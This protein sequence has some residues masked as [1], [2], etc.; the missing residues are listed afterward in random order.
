MISGQRKQRTCSAQMFPRPRLSVMH[1][2]AFSHAYGHV[3]GYNLVTNLRGRGQGR[4]RG[5]SKGTTVQFRALGRLSQELYR[6][7][8]QRT[9]QLRPCNRWALQLW[10]EANWASKAE[11]SAKLLCVQVK[12][13][14]STM[15]P[16]HV[17]IGTRSLTVWPTRTAVTSRTRAMRI[18]G[19]LYTGW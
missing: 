12:C 16:I 3:V 6:V 7:R 9:R 2:G 13:R 5:V 19:G 4:D 1:M 8:A 14:C 15:E 10:V 17:R 18:T 11:V